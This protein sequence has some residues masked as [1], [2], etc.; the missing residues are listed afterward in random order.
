MRFICIEPW[1]SIPS[2]DNSP[3]E[4]EKKPCAASLA[5]DEMWQTTLNVTFER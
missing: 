1:H 4:W 2:E 3:I 5:P